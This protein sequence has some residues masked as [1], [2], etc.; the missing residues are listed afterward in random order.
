MELKPNDFVMPSGGGALVGGFEKGC[1]PSTQP[2]LSRLLSGSCRGEPPA[3]H[4]DT[5]VLQGDCVHS[6]SPPRL[7]STQLRPWPPSLFFRS[8]APLSVWH[9]PRGR[10]RFRGLT[11]TK[12]HLSCSPRPWLRQ[13]G[14][15]EERH[16]VFQVSGASALTIHRSSRSAHQVCITRWA[17]CS[18][19]TPTIGITPTTTLSLPPTDRKTEA[20]KVYVTCNKVAVPGPYIEW[21]AL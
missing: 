6:P 3:Q 7:P 9:L 4:G 15:W 12:P 5:A 2:S 18:V 20:W 17:L 1:C 13:G 10:A 11:S 14:S 16:R 8:S 21:R 19:F